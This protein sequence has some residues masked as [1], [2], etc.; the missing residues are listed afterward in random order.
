MQIAARGAQR[1]PG[2]VIVR[3]ADGTETIVSGVELPQPETVGDK[4]L[5]LIG[6]G[7]VFAVAVVVREWHVRR[8]SRGL[9]REGS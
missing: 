6:L 5:S 9:R 3:F 2:Q 7:L 8:K 1:G 4:Y